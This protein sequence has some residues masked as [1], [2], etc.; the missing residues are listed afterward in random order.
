M[1]ETFEQYD[2][3]RVLGRGYQ[4][5]VY[6]V[7]TP[8]GNQYAMKV[9][10]VLPVHVALPANPAS[11]VWREIEFCSV[12]NKKYPDMFAQMRAHLI[13]YDCDHDQA[14]ELDKNCKDADDRERLLRRFATRI[15]SVFFY[16]LL[17]ATLGE[18]YAAP[19]TIHPNVSYD[20][21]IQCVNIVRAMRR[22]KYSHGDLSINNIMVRET[23]KKYLVIANKRVP[24]HG[25]QCAAIDF[26]MV[27]PI[28]PG[29]PE[30][31]C[32]MVSLLYIAAGMT[33]QCAIPRKHKDVY[34]PPQYAAK[35]ALII[36]GV[37]PAVRAKCA[38][39]MH[40]LK[41]VLFKLLFFE[42]YNAILKHDKMTYTEFLSHDSIVF[43]VHHLFEPDT[44]LAYLLNN[45]N[46]H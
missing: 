33:I 44:V 14:A 42:Q 41:Q 5:V 12:M 16:D 6:L 37:D 27:A 40:E 31:V 13:N 2:I 46:K 20:I 1:R 7:Q 4:G 18:L 29:K 32:D 39:L 21:F 30:C 36:S 10:P 19:A 15:C 35:L 34:I 8:S 23:P 22:E 26:A 24:T 11:P 17:D 9:S 38:T 43:I 3:K 45:K 28:R 25:Y